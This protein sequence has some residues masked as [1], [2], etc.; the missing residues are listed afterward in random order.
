MLE[1]GIELHYKKENN[2]SVL[3]NEVC[4]ILIHF[5]CII[6]KSF[7]LFIYFFEI[8]MKHLWEIPWMN[9]LDSRTRRG[10]VE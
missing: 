3:Q 7:I 2:K 10:R 8:L 1:C 5:L 4:M 9:L 6:F